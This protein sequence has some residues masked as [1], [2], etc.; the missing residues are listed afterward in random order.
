MVYV[1]IVSHR[2]LYFV[3]TDI[4]IISKII[5]IIDACEYSHIFGLK[6]TSKFKFYIV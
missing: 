3:S 4:L 2:L 5:V 6:F 1:N